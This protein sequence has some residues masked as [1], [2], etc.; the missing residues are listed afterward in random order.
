MSLKPWEQ[1]GEESLAQYKVFHV[2]KARR[3]SPRTGQDIGFFIL[4]TVDWVNVVA[5]TK[6]Q[7]LILVRQY[8]HGTCEFALEIPGGIVHGDADAEAAARRELREETGY[9][10][11]EF[12]CIGRAAPNPAFLTNHITTFLATGCELS[13]ELIQDQGEDLEVVLVP[14]DQ[15]APK[16]RAGEIDHAL[17]LAGLYFHEL[18]G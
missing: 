12:V 1:L 9:V 10:P 18:Q 13:G 15:I 17:V 6:A 7:E 16:V 5:F 14:R 11:G 2:R 4:D 3:R 8:R